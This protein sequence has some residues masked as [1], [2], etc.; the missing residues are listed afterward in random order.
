MCLDEIIRQGA[1]Q[2]SIEEFRKDL[3]HME[4]LLEDSQIVPLGA[5]N[6]G[7]IVKAAPEYGPCRPCREAERS[8]E[9]T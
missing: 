6:Y 4:A 1:W 7:R 9:K 8:G 3:Q 5:D 2:K